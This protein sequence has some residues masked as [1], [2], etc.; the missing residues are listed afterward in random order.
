M[1]TCTRFTVLSLCA[2]LAAGPLSAQGFEGS[3]AYKTMSENGKAAEMVMSMKGT[4][5]RTDANTEGHGM[6]MLI[7]GEG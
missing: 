4:K 5:M 7:D 1:P 6:T 2:A 3:V